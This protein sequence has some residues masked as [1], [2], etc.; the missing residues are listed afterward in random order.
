MNGTPR[1][2]PPSG[3]KR[4]C[5]APPKSRAGAYAPRPGAGPGRAPRRT[6]SHDDSRRPVRLVL[7]AEPP[8]LTPAAARTLLRILIKAHAAQGGEHEMQSQQPA[9][10]ADGREAGT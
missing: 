3:R 10:P 4:P 8:D 6:H 1:R 7:P 5:S 9:L 2:P